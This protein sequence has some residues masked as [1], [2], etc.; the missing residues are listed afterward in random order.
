MLGIVYICLSTVLLLLCRRALLS[1]LCSKMCG[2][3]H[4]MSCGQDFV[5]G[6]AGVHLGAMSAFWLKGLR[7]AWDA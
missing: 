4:Q 5:A 7:M 3:Q 1:H 2:G 6:L